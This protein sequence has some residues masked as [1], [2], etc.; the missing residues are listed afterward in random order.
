M[1]TGTAGTTLSTSVANAGTVSSQCTV[2]ST[3]NWTGVSDFIVGANQ[4]TMSNLGPIQ[5]TGDG[6][7]YPAQSLNFNN[8]AHND[9]N[10]NTNG[11]LTCSAPA[12]ATLVSHCA[13]QGKRLNGSCETGSGPEF[14]S[15]VIAFH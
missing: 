12:R 1:N 9:A 8:I 11:Y 14:L 7:L 2:G 10:N 4:G 6:P 3:R 5:M 15:M 13:E